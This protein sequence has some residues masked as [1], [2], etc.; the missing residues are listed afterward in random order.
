MGEETGEECE[1]VNS[2]NTELCSCLL[3]LLFLSVLYIMWL[4][5]TAPVYLV[6]EPVWIFF[7]TLGWFL[8]Q[9]HMN[10]ER[11]RLMLMI[12]FLMIQCWFPKMFK[13]TWDVLSDRAP[14]NKDQ[15]FVIIWNPLKK[16]YIYPL[17]VK[18][19]QSIRCSHL[20]WAAT[21]LFSLSVNL[22]MIFWI[23]WLVI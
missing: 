5:Q 6:F 20:C 16:L 17:I 10:E 12:L 8:Q 19:F 21:Q 18:I 9:K 2:Y 22:L 11:K 3:G 13:L 23:N 15:A 1:H 14:R 4:L 7:C